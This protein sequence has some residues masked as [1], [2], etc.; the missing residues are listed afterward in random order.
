MND[1]S[2]QYNNVTVQELASKLNLVEKHQ[3]FYSIVGV[4]ESMMISKPEALNTKK[5]PLKM[6][7]KSSAD[8]SGR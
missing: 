1:S 7:N 4:S 6:L 3:R 5:L 8:L 2:Q